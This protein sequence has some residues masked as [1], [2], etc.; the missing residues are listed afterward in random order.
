M[1]LFLSAK[2]IFV[3]RFSKRLSYFFYK[4]IRRRAILTH[5]NKSYTMP[6]MCNINILHALT[7]SRSDQKRNA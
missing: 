5:H 2:I 1:P 6:N 7:E 3:F 4:Y